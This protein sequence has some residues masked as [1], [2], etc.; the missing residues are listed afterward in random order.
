M[1]YELRSPIAD[2]ALA[3]CAYRGCIR[4][5]FV[6]LVI[7]VV[8]CAPPTGS[9][10]GRSPSTSVLASRATPSPKESATPSISFAGAGL[11]TYALGKI[12]GTLAWVTRIGGG[13]GPVGQ[14][15]EYR[16]VWMVPIDGGGPRLAVRYRAQ[17]DSRLGD[18]NVLARQLS[19]DG[20]RLVLSVGMG[21]IEVND[22]LVVIELESGRVTPL[23]PGERHND[24]SPAWS[25][26]G[27]LIAFARRSHPLDTLDGEV[28]IAAPSGTDAR[29]LLRSSAGSSTYIFG[30][31]P[32]SRRI[33]YDPV[34]WEFM[35]YAI[36]DLAGQATNVV[37]RPVTTHKA[38]SWRGGSPAFV[39]TYQDASRPAQRMDVLVGDPPG[40]LRSVVG[41]TADATGQITSVA[42]PSWDPN[43]SDV[44]LYREQGLTS[45]AVLLEISSGG[46]KRI[47]G[48]TKAAEWLPRGDGIVTVSDEQSS[49]LDVV[50]VWA[51]DGAQRGSD[52]RL[53]IAEGYRIG[54]LAVRNY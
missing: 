3:P 13:K 27:A 17:Y 29:R 49:G 10:L 21:E 14:L 28:W 45:A 50:R 4:S 8:G 51:R 16:E 2:A 11:E 38:V 46:P 54:D 22:A 36:V 30:W 5:L 20:K 7:A 1:E 9:G 18:T 24:F 15:P 42:D 41:H 52:L 23:F 12:S 19:P 39:G 31:L 53:P 35:S 47:G 26:D 44:L 6:F 34:N 40:A 33:G 32:D 25:P 48:R 37:A 43:G